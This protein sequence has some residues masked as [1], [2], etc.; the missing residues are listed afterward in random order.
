MSEQNTNNVEQIRDI[1]FGAKIKEFEEK[2]H[3][4]N[5]T[6]QTLEETM[7]RTFHESHLKLQKET[8][9]SLEVLEK[10]IDTLASSTQR[11]KN[12][13]KELIDKT[14]EGLNNQLR[15]QKDEFS[16]K[17]KMMRE[18]VTDD[19]QKISEDMESMKSEIQTALERGL[20]TLSEEKLSRDAMAQML[21]NVAMKIQGTD[22]HSIVS[23]EQR[24][25]K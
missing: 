23:Q 8:E 10:K 17:M 7:K 9:R 25:D 13:L 3:L 20:S 18:N 14:E 24:P 5:Q 11:E 21:L 4:F 19:T 6:L 22:I 16:S 1:I 2:F 12:N 15:S